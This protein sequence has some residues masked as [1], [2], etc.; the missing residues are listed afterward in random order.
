[1][2]ADSPVFF[3]DYVRN[4]KAKN[5]NAKMPGNPL[6]D[7]KTLHALTLYFQDFAASGATM[8]LRV[9]KI[10]LVFGVAIF[11]AFV[12]F[13]NLTDYDSNYQIRSA[14]ADDGF[15]FPRKS[16]DVAR[17]ES[18]GPAHGILCGDYCVGNGHDGALLVGRHSSAENAARNRCGISSGEERR[19]CGAH[20]E[21]ADVAGGIFGRWR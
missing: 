21:P 4:P 9:A 5:P 16:R 11:Y 12:V 13:N 17:D 10:A 14:R 2:A 7:E 20:R 18:T 1:M 3:K 15:H 8:S 6:Y 19:G